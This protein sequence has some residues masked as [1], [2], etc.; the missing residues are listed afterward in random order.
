MTTCRRVSLALAT[1]GLGGV[2]AL[3][4]GLQA[5]V[6]F[7][8]V[9]D[10]VVRADALYVFPGQVP[11]RAHC[12]ADLFRR[13]T[14]PVVV[15]TGERIQPELAA[16]G[17]MLTDADINARLLADQGVPRDA[18]VVRREGTSTWEDAQAVRRWSTEQPHVHRLLAVT[19]SAHSRRARQTLRQAFRGTGID[20]R[21]RPCP[22]E[23]TADWWKHEET[24]LRV[25]NEYLKLAYYAVAH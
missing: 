11:E 1:L 18:I 6:S 21:V 7:L 4:L 3:P 17:V 12:A 25:I 20:V 9:A 8:V 15:V 22:P 10:P 16:V 14:A 5:A 2:L 24:L 19:S 23:L 13:G